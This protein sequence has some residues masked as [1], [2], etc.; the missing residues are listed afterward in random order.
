MS[1]DICCAAYFLRSFNW[2]K[3]SLLLPFNLKLAIISFLETIKTLIKLVSK[4]THEVTFFLAYILQLVLLLE[5]LQLCFSCWW[6]CVL[7]EL[8]SYLVATILLKFKQKFFLLDCFNIHWDFARICF[9]EFKLHLVNSINVSIL[10]SL[11]VSFSLTF[12]I[13]EVFGGEHVRL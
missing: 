3:R 7:P 8:V 9:S 12:Q 5:K 10:Q 4:V 13:L 2:L 6:A 1:T 11:N